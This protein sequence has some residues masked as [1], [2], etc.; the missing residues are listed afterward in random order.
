MTTEHNNLHYDRILVRF[1]ELSTKG[2]NK[3]DFINRLL[4]N[5][6]KALSGFANLKYEKTHDRLYLVLNGEDP[7]EVADILKDVFGI[8]SFSFVITV[9]NQIET[10]VDTA[11]QLA[12]AST[13]AATFKINTRRPYKQ[14]YMLSDEINRAVATKILQESELKVDVHNPDL[15]IGV[16]IQ[17]FHAS[18]MTDKILGAGGYPVGVGGKALLMLSGGIDSPVAAY[19]TMKRGVKVEAIHFA[20]PPYTSARAQQ[21][22]MDLAAITSRFQGDMKVHVIPFTELQLAIYQNCDLPYAITIM[23]RMMYRIAERYAR[24]H[25]MG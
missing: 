19:M 9:P 7:Q 25:R 1:G 11:Y 14:F 2:K 18:I 3:K 15:T 13:D 8:Y 23:R 24:T 6:K 4:N 22:V 12:M 20:S 5:T 17:Q 10:I 21:K 16:E